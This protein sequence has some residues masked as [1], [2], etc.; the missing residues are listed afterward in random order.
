MSEGNRSSCS[1]CDALTE[2]ACSDCVIDGKGRVAICGNPACMDVHERAC[3]EHA[4]WR[5]TKWPI[6]KGD[7]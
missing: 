5:A 3:P 6:M 1:I 7:L 2:Y 4:Q